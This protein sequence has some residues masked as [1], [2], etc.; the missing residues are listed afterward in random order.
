MAHQQPQQQRSV[1]QDT[2]LP[3]KSTM[4]ENAADA[5]CWKATEQSLNNALNN[6]F[7]HHSSLNQN[8]ADG[9]E[10]ISEAEKSELF[11]LCLL[12]FLC[13]ELCR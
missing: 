10:I 8:A 4:T 9:S 11:V 2:Y 1:Y 7:K 3:V 5:A 12:N 6:V 13:E